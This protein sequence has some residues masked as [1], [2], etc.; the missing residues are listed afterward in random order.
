M[1]MLSLA[2]L[3]SLQLLAAQV[4][5]DDASWQTLSSSPIH[6]ECATVR[7]EP[8]CRSTGLISAPIDDVTRSLRDMR[9]NAGNFKSIV[10]ID[11]LDA[12]TIRVVLDYPTPLDDRDYVARYSYIEN[13]EARLFRW[14]SAVHPSAP[15]VPGI[16]RLPKFAGEWRLEVRGAS[17]WV[18]YTWQAEIQGS[19]PAMG[20]STAWKRAGYEA[21]KDLAAT[22]GASLTAAE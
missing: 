11:V 20:Y 15:E 2:S 7:S 22:R 5:G 21:L 10:Q 17:T 8:W 19:F 16:V 12:E 4:P 9:Y 3:L 14:V 6:V 1:M 13:A 18:R